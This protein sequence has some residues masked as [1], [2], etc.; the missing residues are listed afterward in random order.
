MG[1]AR[2]RLALVVFLVAACGSGT[3]PSPST[4]TS[5]TP[6]APSVSPSLDP[7]AARR[8][9]LEQLVERL[10]STHPNPFLDEG[11]AA[12]RA[13][14]EA[15]AATAG[16]RS[17]AGFMVD[18]M[19]LMG[20]RD[21]DGHSGAW[22]MAQQGDRLHVL[23]LWLRE[24]PDGLRIVTAKAP[25]EDLVGG[26]VTAVGGT[27]VDAARRLVT[28]LVPADNDSNR[29]ANLPMYLL[30]DEV[31]DELGIQRP[32][33]ARLSL[34]FDDGTTRDVD[35]DALPIGVFRDWIFGVYPDF[36][37]GLP[38]DEQGT[39]DRQRRDEAFWTEVL[40]DGTLY[41]AYQEVR[42]RSGPGGNSGMTI[43]ALANAVRDAKGGVVVDLRVNPGGDNT[44]Y[45][46]FR[47]AV[48]DVAIA[49]P[50]SVALLTSRDTFSAAGNFV[51]ELKVGEGGEGILLVGEPAGGGLDIYGDVAA[52]TLEHTGI[53]VL[54]SGR[55]H[56]MAPGDDRLQIEPDV[57]AEATWGD[58][59]AGRDTVLD[60]AL[61]AITSGEAP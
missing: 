43:G 2:C 21:R 57:P 20:H 61:A 11:E 58:V 30:V 49:R 18:V 55:Y 12:Y 36:P 34:R 25:N 54:I 10:D 5:A 14:V 23:P 60:A 22:A 40:P 35:A 31:V 42:R 26:V 51:T 9:D 8:E 46:T 56:E 6:P 29:R 33:A 3:T 39:R 15:V 45:G 27:P 16:Q 4:D 59:M 52:V 7:A 13:R 17:D 28:P 37:T 24:F 48:R 32:G 38:P 47:D 50:R 53:V 44:T 41:I 1:P 19:G